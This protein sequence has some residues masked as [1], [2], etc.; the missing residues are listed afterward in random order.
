MGRDNQPQKNSKNAHSFPQTPKQQMIPAHR[1]NE[2]FSREL[3]ELEK[4]VL[5][6]RAKIKK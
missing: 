2:E 4:L 6:R 1:V 3:S 5:K